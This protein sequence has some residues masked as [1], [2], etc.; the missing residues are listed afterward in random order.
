M[1]K[2]ETL[3]EAMVAKDELGEAELRYQLLA[4]AFE[5]LPQMRSQLNA[6][7]ERAKAEILRLRAVKPAANTNGSESGKVVAFDAARFRKSG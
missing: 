5:E 6:Q 3:N 7:I 1:A 2:Y 4:E